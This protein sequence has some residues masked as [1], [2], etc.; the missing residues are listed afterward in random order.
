MHLLDPLT[1]PIL[2][3]AIAGALIIILYKS[4]K[5]LFRLWLGVS[6][7]GRVVF[8]IAA[9]ILCVYSGTKPNSGAQQSRTSS[10]L[11]DT[12]TEDEIT[13]GYVTPTE[14]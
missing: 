4:S 1:F 7:P 5:P 9:L 10:V 11:V 2:Y 6:G 3:A 13:S 8:V 12:V 14:V